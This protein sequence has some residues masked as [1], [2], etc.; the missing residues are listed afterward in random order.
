[1][2]RHAADLARL[3]PGEDPKTERQDDIEHWIV[4]YRELTAY[5]REL[6]RRLARPAASPDPVHA[7][8]EALDLPLAQAHALR[9]RL[10]LYY[11]MARG[12]RL[13]KSSIAKVKH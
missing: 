8:P 12:R 10:R 6:I 7:A 9:I 4:T 2:I 3:L 11:W 13:R 1:N 5:N